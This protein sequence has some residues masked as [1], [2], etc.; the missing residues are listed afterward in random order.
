ML[1]TTNYIKRSTKNRM[2]HH[3]H[4]ELKKCDRP[5]QKIGETQISGEAIIHELN[6]QNITLL[7]FIFDAY[8]SMGPIVTSYF[9]KDVNVPSITN[10]K[11]LKKLAQPVLKAY[12]KEETIQK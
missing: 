5:P 4:Y 6:E 3:L 12:K 1:N 10:K 2:K 11:I 8:G 7:P 9:Y